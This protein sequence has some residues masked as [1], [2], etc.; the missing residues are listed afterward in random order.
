MGPEDETRAVRIGGKCLSL[1]SNMKSLLARYA[2]TF[3]PN[4]PPVERVTDSR[5]LSS[6]GPVSLTRLLSENHFNLCI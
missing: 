6:I 4:H 1:L 5:I 3:P 2:N